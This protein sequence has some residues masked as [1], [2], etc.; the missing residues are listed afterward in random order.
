MTQ[1]T[2]SAV[3]DRVR[4]KKSLGLRSLCSYLAPIVTRKDR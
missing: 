2:Q 1:M 3:L 4:V